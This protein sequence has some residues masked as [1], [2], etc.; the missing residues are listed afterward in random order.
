VSL[1]AGIHRGERPGRLT[2]DREASQP[3]LKGDVVLPGAPEGV[4]PILALDSG[5][6]QSQLF[7]SQVVRETG[8]VLRPEWLQRRDSGC[9]L[10][11]L[12]PAGGDL[13]E[14]IV[15]EKRGRDQPYKESEE[16]ACRRFPSAGGGTRTRTP[17]GGTPDFKSGAYHQFRHPGRRRIARGS[18]EPGAMSDTLP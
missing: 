4:A 5:A 12:P 15:V 2:L 11:A 17:P 13:H 3:C 6:E 18:Y 7:V 14:R 9:R 16:G 8:E 1:Q 10:E